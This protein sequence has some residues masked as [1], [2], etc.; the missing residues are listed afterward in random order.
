MPARGLYK[1]VAEQVTG[2]SVPF[3][4]PWPP[5]LFLFLPWLPFLAVYSS[6]MYLLHFVLELSGVL[7]SC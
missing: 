5:N 2:S 7:T 1:K 6:W 4:T 3:N